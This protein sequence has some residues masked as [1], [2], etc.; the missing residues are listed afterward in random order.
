M[1]MEKWG[2][3]G[4]WELLVWG[5]IIGCLPSPESHRDSALTELP[6]TECRRSRIQRFQL[7]APPVASPQH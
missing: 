4:V 5:A 1:T 6:I 7:P 2:S 3:W